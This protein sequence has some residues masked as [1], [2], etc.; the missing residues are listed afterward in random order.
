MSNVP[1]VELL[2][3]RQ[4]VALVQPVRIALGVQAL[5]QR[6]L[7]DKLQGRS[8]GFRGHLASVRGRRDGR[9]CAGNTQLRPISGL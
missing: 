7:L 2:E 4:A 9:Q 5:T 8:C 1:G 6:G 3:Q